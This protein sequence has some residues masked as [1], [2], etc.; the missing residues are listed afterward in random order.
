[1][2]S[3]NYQIFEQAMRSRKQIVCRY[4]GYRRELCPIVL[5]HSRGQEKALT[6][7]FG[8]DSKS[9]LPAGGEWRCLW[10]SKVSDAQLRDGPWLA[11]ASHSQPQGCVEEVDLDINP[12]SPYQPKRRIPF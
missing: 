11:G 3:V 12:T 9:G 1:M 6:Y 5:G 10:L 7:Q 4:G 8:G 2:A